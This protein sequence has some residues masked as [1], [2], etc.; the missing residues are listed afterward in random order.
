MVTVCTGHGVVVDSICLSDCI[1]CW[2]VLELTKLG[3]MFDSVVTKGEFSEPRDLRL[4]RMMVGA[5]AGSAAR[6][7][8]VD[9]SPRH[10]P[11][12]RRPPSQGQCSVVPPPSLLALCL[13]AL[14][15]CCVL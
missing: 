13:L 12:R 10:R 1:H 9:H 8:A 5:A 2:L 3:S 15:E 4:L 6:V 7:L 14:C 11:R